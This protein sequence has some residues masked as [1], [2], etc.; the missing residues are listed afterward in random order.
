LEEAVR[1][2]GWSSA[3]DRVAEIRRLKRELSWVT[4]ERDI[5]KKATAYF[6][7]DATLSAMSISPAGQ[8]VRYAFVVEHSS[9]LSVRVM[10][11]CLRIQPSDHYAWLNNPR[12]WRTKDDARQPELIRTACKE[13]AKVYGDR[14]LRD[15]LV[16][17][18]ERCCPIRV[19]RLFK[20][21]GI[22][23]QIDYKRQTGITMAAGQGI[24]VA[25]D[26]ELIRPD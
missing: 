26:K 24:K 11:R 22:R 13:S 10:C 9:Q 20:L 5:Q 8:G 3:D 1:E 7:K 14:K 16:E 23:A 6:A 25:K 19:S 4:E 12:S 21:A 2:V 17:Q 18:G 15:D